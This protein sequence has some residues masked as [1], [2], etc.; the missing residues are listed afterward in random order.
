MIPEGREGRTIGTL[1]T[2]AAQKDI[3]RSGYQEIVRLDHARF[4]LQRRKW[5]V[6]GQMAEA[7]ETHSAA[8]PIPKGDPEKPMANRSTFMQ[9]S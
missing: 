9:V 7:K 3:V 2:S 4:W 5:T 8:A 6:T 1:R